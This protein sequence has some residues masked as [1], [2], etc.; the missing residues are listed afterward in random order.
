MPIGSA[1]VAVADDEERDF[2]P[3]R[4]SS[5]TSRSPAAPNRRSLIAATTAA[6]AVGAIV[7][8]DDA[9]AGGE[10]VG[11]QHDRKPELA[12]PRR[13]RS[14]S[15]SD[16]QV[17][18][19]AVGTPWR[20]MNAFANALLDSRRAAAAV[21]PK[22]SRPSAAKRSAT[23]RLSGSSGP[24]T[25][26]SICSRSASSS[27]RVRIGEIDGSGARER[28]RSRVPG[29]ADDLADVAIGGEP[30]DERVLARAAAENQNSHCLNGLG[31]VTALHGDE[32]PSGT[33]SLTL[34][35]IA[36]RIRVYL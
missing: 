19:R 21:G 13:T 11:L 25:V 32:R 17:R 2:G 6:S 23:P 29:R 35:G 3:D 5:I 16:S 26:R 20:A 7:G 31:R 8:D 30:R 1:R 22:S 15:S 27:E 36:P 10:T 34:T 14:A 18:K 28:A 9:F 4:H 24:T 12:G 33:I